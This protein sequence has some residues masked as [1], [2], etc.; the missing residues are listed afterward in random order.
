MDLFAARGREKVNATAGR[1]PTQAVFG[2][3]APGILVQESAGLVPI[4]QRH[5]DRMRLIRVCNLG[6]DAVSDESV[7]H[8]GACGV[9]INGQRR[10]AAA[11]TKNRQRK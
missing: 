1:A 4:A 2:R 5:A 7:R 8:S 10:H 3:C 9:R 6:A 11:E